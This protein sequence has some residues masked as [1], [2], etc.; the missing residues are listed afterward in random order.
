MS[1]ELDFTRVEDLLRSV[2]AP[3]DPPARYAQVAKEAALGQDQP[4]LAGSLRRAPRARP[5]RG[6]FAL[7]GALV[8]ALAA[9]LAI[10][11]FSGGSSP[12]KVESSVPLVSGS[13]TFALASGSLDLGAPDGAM[14][15]AVLKVSDLPPAPKGE[16]YEM[17]FSDGDDKV[18]MMA[19]NTAADG[20]VEVQG[21]VPAG[22]TW[23]H[24]WVSLERQA[25]NGDTVVK[26]VLRSS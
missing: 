10:A 24:C 4:G 1:D 25:P 18:G 3:A 14:R 11:V 13:S 16:Y 12:M 2:P 19:F 21:A 23:D 15:P 22:M 5:R 9:T 7:G 20:T 17:W 6:W 26:P 8:G